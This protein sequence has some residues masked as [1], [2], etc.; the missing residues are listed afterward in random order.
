MSD[1]KVEVTFSAIIGPF[2][3]GVNS[4][5]EAINQLSERAAE[6][7]EGVAK[8][9]ESFMHLAELAGVEIGVSAFKEWANSTTE[10]AEKMQQAGAK[11]GLTARDASVLSGVAKLTG[12]SFDS[13]ESSMERFQLRLA[14]TN[15]GTD[16]VSKGL[17]ALGLSAR[18][19]K[20]A[21]LDGQMD[22]LAEA[23]SRFQD[24]PTKTAAAMAVLGR[25]GA[26]MIPYLD[27]GKEGLQEMRDVLE[28]TGAVMS[29]EMVAAFAKTREDI[30]ELSL[31]WQGFSNKLFTVV[32]PAIEAVI[33]QF[34]R[35]LESLKVEDIQRATI[36]I[37]DI[38]VDGAARIAEF[39]VRA[40]AAWQAMVS[41]I[42]GVVDFVR[43][44]MATIRDMLTPNQVQFAVGAWGSLLGG[45]AADGGAQP[46]D[47][48]KT[49]AGIRERAESIK[50]AYEDAV[51]A[52]NPVANA[53]PV[54]DKRPI[55]PQL[56]LGGG[57][58]KAN[59]DALRAQI[60]AIDDEIKATQEGAAQKRKILDDLLSH[61]KISMADWLAATKD[62]IDDATSDEVASYQRELALDGL[63]LQQ[64]QAI[65]NR[66]AEVVRQ[67]ANQTADA[68][69][70]AADESWR[71]WQSFS[72][73]IS[74]AFAGQVGGILKGTTSLANGM[75]NAFDQIVTSWAAACVKMGINWLLQHA[76]M[77]SAYTSFQ[78]AV[79]AATAAGESARTGIVASSAATGAA[80]K[81]AAAATEI[82]GDA[83]RAAAGAYAAVAG[84]PII[85]PI[86]APA[87]AAVAFGAVEAFGSFDQGSWQLPGNMLAQVHRGEM[88]VPAAATPW[89]QALMSNA[90]SGGGGSGG[91]PPNV[92]LH[93][94]SV[95]AA[96]TRD[97]FMRN[98]HHVVSALNEA[99]R[100]G[101]HLGLSRL[102]A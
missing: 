98:S 82:S 62:A 26:D 21:S 78:A 25:A 68:E 54:R 73:Q 29:N 69:R 52:A 22:L 47:T 7:S 15:D 1:S 84:I 66:I 60:A 80:L 36:Q 42:S 45:D 8:L 48:D 30:N 102:P 13:L 76:G 11:L 74:G 67:S 16:E 32:N 70:K 71:A 17:K 38:L 79:T 83:G 56:D 59:N 41:T 5:R 3:E 87:A 58:D 86:I 101:N 93:V 46:S 77:E 61:Q 88:I 4:I 55:V 2:T 50:K 85:G 91:G 28:R 19:L 43:D 97:W 89:A 100:G 40:Q 96:S 75:I 33:R 90:A 9:R 81:K 65:Q 53:A 31:A 57:K 94:S 20:A 24:S 23:F 34:S 64:R 95:D 39:A 72:G 44:K 6:A 18:E 92:S 51:K 14:T 99:V 63:K 12:T 37:V 49:I 27:K 35:W 10:L